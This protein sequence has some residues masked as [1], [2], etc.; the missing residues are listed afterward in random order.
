MIDEENKFKSEENKNFSSLF[1]FNQKYKTTVSFYCINEILIFENQYSSDK[2]IEE[3]IVDFLNKETDENLMKL[4]DNG[5]YFSKKNLSFYIKVN[6]KFEK[7]EY[8]KLISF[9]ATN[10]ISQ[11]HKGKNIDSIQTFSEPLNKNLKI[12]VKNENRYK[13]ISNN[14][15]EYIINNTIYIGKP[16]INRFKC[17]IY[18]KISKEIKI[19][20]FSKE[21]KNKL[22]IKSFS[23]ICTYCNAKNNLYIYEGNV[24]LYSYDNNKFIQINLMNNKI[25]LI[26]SKFPN[27]IL[28]S[29]IYIPECYIFIIGGKKARNVITYS[30]KENNKNYEQYPH[31][32]PY[33]MLEPSLVC[34]N[35]KYL[36]GFENST[37]D[38]HILRTNFIKI[39]PFEEIK[40]KNNQYNVEQ[41]FFGVVKIKDSIL[42]VGGQMLNLFNNS[43]KK[44]YLYNYENEI[45]EKCEREFKPYD[46]KE[47]TFIPIEKDLYMQLADIKKEKKNE[48]KIII[49]NER[50]NDNEI[51][52]KRYNTLD[53]IKYY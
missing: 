39:K 5:Q 4:L 9:Y 50:I 8:E 51:K 32:L 47:K 40:L 38:F 28:H 25:N 48:L 35:N 6:G 29:M 36:Y 20:N 1:F 33:E 41:K 12:Y 7:L 31:L 42:F 30:F 2:S 45:L 49:F 26:S 37:L 21:E 53:C 11:I 23:G 10:S 13:Y 15:E 14:I 16:I 27:R 24:D 34:I 44:C 43:S 22:K 18:N 17:Y 52:M 46:F 3:I 19:V